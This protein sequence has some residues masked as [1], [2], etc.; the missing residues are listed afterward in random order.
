MQD[1]N[2]DELGTLLR[3]WRA[4]GAPSALE[5][6]VVAAA[7]FSRLQRWL[8][9]LFTGTIRVPAPVGIGLAIVLLWLVFQ[10]VRPAPS[11][12]GFQ[13]VQEFK[14]RLIRSFHETN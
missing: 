8:Q 14:P 3:Q 2:D 6:R 1:L 4:P 12:D 9:W 5:D 13:P 7:G 10:S 11:F